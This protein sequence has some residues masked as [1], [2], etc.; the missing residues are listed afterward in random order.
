MGPPTMAQR[1]DL[2]EERLMT[3]DESIKEMVSQTV[4]KAMEAMRHSLTEVLMEGQGM[5]N[6]KLGVDF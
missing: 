6:K 5:A 3:L 4:D 2:I 1:L